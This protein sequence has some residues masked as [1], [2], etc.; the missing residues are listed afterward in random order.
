M[1]GSSIMGIIK[2]LTAALTAAGIGISVNKI[3]V[4][5]FDKM[6][7][8]SDVVVL[9]VRT[10]QEFASGKIPGAVSVD[11]LAND[12]A[13]KISHFD[14]NKTYLVYCGHGVRSV[15]ACK[16]MMKMNFKNCYSLIGGF[17]VWK[18]AGKPIEK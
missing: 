17:S 10:P 12:F 7:S 2:F 1:I 8:G 4:D 16:I 13:D 5:E 18:E 15:T 14:R 11:V 6:R 3:N 9:D